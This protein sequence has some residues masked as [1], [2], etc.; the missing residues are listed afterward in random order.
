MLMPSVE[1]LDA[2]TRLDFNVFVERVFAELYGST[3]YLDNAHIA[4]VCAELE[5]VRRGENL[6]LALALPPRSLKSMIVSV[7]YPA[8]LLGHSPAAKIIC[9][10]YAQPLA[11]D[12][13][14][15]CLQIMQSDWYRRVFPATRLVNNR[16]PVAGFETTAGGFRRATSVGGVLT[17]FGADY[18][19]VDDPSKPSEAMSDVE[20]AKANRWAQHTLFT[21][22]NDKVTGRIIIVM[23]RLHEDDMIG[24]VAS[25]SP[26]KIVSF[27]AI[28]QADESFRI[29]TSHGHRIWRRIEGEALHPEREPI[30]VLL[31]LKTAMGPRDFSAQYLQMPAPPGGS[32]V[33]PEWFPRF[34]LA[35]P[36]TFDRV[37]Q[38][39]DT[40]NKPGQFS[41]YSVCTTWGKRG[42]QMFLLHVS[43]KRLEFPD[44]KRAIIE[45]AR[46][47]DAATV[48]IEDAGS[49]IGLLQ[50]LRNDAFYKAKAVK[51]KGDKIL[52]MQAQTGAIEAGQVFVPTSAPWLDDY[53]HELM[54]FPASKYDDQVDSTSQALDQANNGN[55]DVERWI[56]Y[57]KERCQPPKPDVPFIRVNHIEPGMQ[58]QLRHGRRP[59]R[60]PD[61]SFL[62]TEEEYGSMA[63][64]EGLTV[65]DWPGDR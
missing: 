12:L 57:M 2:L 47:F 1:E 62:V 25:V 6:K 31:A 52:R 39:W 21:R 8:W 30:E 48:L 60:G 54:M 58:F 44:L 38:S 37:I 63:S 18:I 64:I 13:A 32:I 11:D 53:L 17:G 23:Q 61:G 10:S 59:V 24:F 22:L 45:Q 33:K 55:P 50:D 36:P 56:S 41:D 7:T 3:P 27:A 42:K 28:A 49:G 40:A 20:R 16:Q 26:L 65:I 4:F 35:N 51:P 29:E 43:R 14:R 46:I 5:S 34:D 15:D 9:A 19:I